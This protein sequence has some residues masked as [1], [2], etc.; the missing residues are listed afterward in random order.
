[1]TMNANHESLAVEPIGAETRNDFWTQADAVL[2]GDKLMTVSIQAALK[3]LILQVVFFGAVYGAV[4]GTYGVSFERSPQILFAALKVPLLLL[5]SGGLTIPCFF[6][7][8][9]LWGL[10][11]DFTQVLRALM[12]TQAAL[13]IILASLSPFTVLWY[14]SMPSQNS[15]EPAV[16]FNSAMFAVASLTAQSLLRHHMRPLL[17]RDRRH[18]VMLRGWIVLYG[19][20]GIQ[21][22]WL[23]RPFIGDP[24]SPVAFFRSGALGNAYVVLW[25]MAAHI[26]GIG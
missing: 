6:V 26:L 13:A 10:R 14:L 17:Q 25:H 19:F 1:M 3:H 16:L 24:E 22:G 21:W 5:V 12:A 9:T 20:I 2:H 4:M 15:Y 23:L 11:A 18:G 7:L 8:Y